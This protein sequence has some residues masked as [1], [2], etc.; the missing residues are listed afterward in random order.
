MTPVRIQKSVPGQ[1]SQDCSFYFLCK[2]CL[3][4]HLPTLLTNVNLPSNYSPRG[5]AASSCRW[6]A[7]LEVGIGVSESRDRRGFS[8]QSRS[9]HFSI[10]LPSWMLRDTAVAPNQVGVLFR[11]CYADYRSNTSEPSNFCQTSFGPQL[12]KY[13]LPQAPFPKILIILLVF[14]FFFLGA[15]NVENEL[16]CAMLLFWG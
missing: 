14:F 6:L 8:Q 1:P 5:V 9:L 16:N 7:V 11:L 2:N 4:S 3:P 13:C 12:Y 15:T 10:P